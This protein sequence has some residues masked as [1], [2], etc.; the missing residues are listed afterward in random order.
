M[1]I[2]ASTKN[3]GGA[4]PKPEPAESNMQAG[5]CDKQKSQNPISTV[6]SEQQQKLKKSIM[7]LQQEQT[8]AEDE[9]KLKL[10]NMQ[11]EH[12]RTYDWSKQ[13]SK[14][15]ENRYNDLAARHDALAAEHGGEDAKPTDIIALNICG[16]NTFAR[17]D[18][19][20]AVEGSR[21]EALF[22][23][24]WEDQLLRDSDGRVVMDVDEY[25]FK[26]ILEFLYMVKIS[27]DDTPPL[28]SIDESHRSAFDAYVD[29]FAVRGR[30]DDTSTHAVSDSGNST[31]TSSSK[32]L[33][34]A[35][36]ALVATMTDEL[37]KIE[38][39]L[40]AEESFV[41]SFTTTVKNKGSSSLGSWKSSVDG[42]FVLDNVGG[43][44]DHP[45]DL[46]L[47]VINL[48]TN[49]SIIT[50]KLSTLCADPAS[51]LAQD[52]SDEAW[53]GDHR[54]LVDG[55]VCYLVEQPHYAVKKLIE[56]LRLKCIMGDGNLEGATPSMP[57][58]DVSLEGEYFARMVRHYFGADSD[59]GRD[60]I[61][62]LNARAFESEVVVDYAHGECFSDYSSDYS[63]DYFSDY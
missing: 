10:K 59:V 46:D 50:C 29:F 11:D 61:N 3:S 40:E 2:K 17:R 51:K 53:R 7:D 43:L 55:K 39:R 41:A 56:Y 5:A 23:G 26:K 15:L 16:Q 13:K 28:P 36:K 18:T 9:L 35:Q 49:G 34:K 14:D 37:D 52:L 32:D 27:S 54:L 58:F 19:L 30:K 57:R 47:G 24:R 4:G 22:S 8:R 12:K 44:G 62:A 42:S 25:V 33:S 45:S 1:K 31:N 6:F 21:L 38:K 60:A 63:S 20:T 48:Y